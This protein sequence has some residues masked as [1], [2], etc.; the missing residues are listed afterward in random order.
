MAGRDGRRHPAGDARREDVPARARAAVA[1]S[2]RPALRGAADRARRLHRVAVV[3][4]RVGARR[5][6]RDRAHRRAPRRRRGLDVP[7]RR[8]R[9]RRRARGAR[10]DRRL[11]RVGRR[12]RPRCCSAAARASCRSWRCC[13]SRAA[14]DARDLVHLVVSVRSPEELLYAGRAARARDDL[15]LHARDAAGFPPAAGPAPR[16]RPR[17]ASRTR[18]EAPRTTAY[19]CGSSGFA[20]AAS[21]SLVDLGLP[22]DRVR[23]ERFGPTA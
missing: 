8:S 15:R 12:T 18:S 19:V 3:L 16:R 10:P 7:A 9:G 23:V 2:R 13:G 1:A 17:A 20:D 11:L 22:A 21:H 14:P 6:E 4:R 5:L